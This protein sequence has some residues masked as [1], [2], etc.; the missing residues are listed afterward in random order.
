MWG[1]MKRGFM[2][3][4]DKECII[5]GDQ[6]V[7][8]RMFEKRVNKLVNLL[9]GLGLKK[10]D[11]VSVLA[12]NSMTAVEAMIAL[13]K[14][15]LVWAPLNFRHHPNEHAYHLNDAGSR[16]LIM[17]RH[18]AEGIETVRDQLETVEHFI[19]DGEGYPGMERYEDL[20][21]KAS[22]KPTE[23]DI[24]DDDP[25]ALMYTSGTTGKAK[26]VL[27]THKSF[28][29][30]AVFTALELGIQQGDKVIYVAPINHGAGILLPP[31][32]MM[33]TPNILISHLDVDYVLKVIQ[34]EKVTTMWL[35]PTIIYFLLAYPKREEF[36]L[37]S[38]KFLPYS[39]AP[40][41]V[42]K[43]K[44]AL[45]VFGPIFAQA[46]GLVE[47]PVITWL[48][49]EE[50]VLGGD[51]KQTR[52]LGSA[53]REV[54]FTKVRVVDSEGNDLPPGEIGEIIVKSP[55]VMKEYWRNPEATAQTLRDGWLY[56][57]DMGYLDEDGYLFIADRKKDMIITGGYNVYPKEVEDV[58]FKHP[59]VMEAAV[60][61][62]PD[63]TW[64]ESVKAFVV[65]KPGAQATEEEI[66][67]FCKENLASYKK[68][69]S[70]EFIDALPKNL[71]GKVLKTELRKPYW[72]GKE[73]KV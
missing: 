46:Y 25:V 54:V 51:E 32:L 38:L 49:R 53:G 56:T 55:L 42:E 62:V 69:K 39:S 57:G 8:Y 66:I 14:S 10:G 26:G 61:G 21:Q 24:D 48:P 5:C 6:R 65:L 23:V 47:C 71:A 31:H 40:I 13:E 52:R 50:H 68:P 9:Y 18:F 28:S 67:S 7:T 34:E 58:I 12:E 70:V 27:H 22:D 16:A 59:A 36:D 30:L 60:I 44:E 64:G 35:A 11:R 37:S 73:R 29:M 17:Q 2:L 43:L 63:E 19:V 3:H 41:A 72:E 15:G 4:P 45:E 20:M 33:G 1:L